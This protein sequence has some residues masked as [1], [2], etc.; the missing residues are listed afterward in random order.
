MTIQRVDNI[1]IVV[2]DLKAAIAFFV[3]L[4]LELEGEA[5]VEGQWVDRIVGLDGVRS[6]IATM[7]TPDGHGRIEL[8]K[9]HTPTAVRAGPEDAP[10]NT[11]GIGRIMFAVDDLDDLLARLRTHGAELVGEV[12]QYEDQYR[13]CY[14]R[15]PEGIIIALAETL[16]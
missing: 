6:D 15:G 4:G 7:R 1:G 10:V 14:V 5:T 2:D 3:E 9:F 13:L 11:L 8:D 12:V 16:S